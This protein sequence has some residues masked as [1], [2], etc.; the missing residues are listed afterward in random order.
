MYMYVITSGTKD[1]IHLRNDCLTQYFYPRY[2]GCRKEGRTA[3]PMFQYSLCW[4]QST[5]I[6]VGAYK[7]SDGNPVCIVARCAA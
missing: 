1:R 5:S 3:Y 4:H 2:S 7:V 6:R